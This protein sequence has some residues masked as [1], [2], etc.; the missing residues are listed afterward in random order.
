MT[1]FHTA[2]FDAHE[3]VCF[4]ADADSGLRAIIAVHWQGPGLAGGGIRMWPYA[5]EQ[6]A[7]TDALR[8]SRA[9]TYKFALADIAIGG[10]KTVVIGDSRT[11]KT[12]ALLRTLGRAVDSLGGRYICGPDVG[13]TP[14]DMVLIGETTTHVRGR[15]GESGDT[16]PATGYGVFQA[17]RAAVRQR[18]GRQDLDGLKVAVQGAGAV[19]AAL[20]RHLH[21]A[22]AQI[23]IADID[24]AAVARAEQA[25][26]AIAMAPQQILTAEADVLAP[27]ALGA[28]LNDES[29]P[30]IR[31]AVICGGANNQL[32]EDRHGDVLAERGIL[33]VPDYV[34][35][36]GGAINASA[37][38]PDYDADRAWQRVGR[39]YDTCGQIFARAE[40]DGIPASRAAD[41]MA[42][43]RIGRL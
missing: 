2:D 33:Y 14:E 39:I 31:A 7:I 20:C 38:G 6:K 42:A 28:V 16:S 37:E 23:I 25:Y 21:E 34:A 4:F 5:D 12:P 19:G 41:R 22:G 35:N 8:L 24:A 27:C 32:A 10:G 3:Q 9:M 40:A 29:I 18:L 13:T 17:L 1:V 15:P 43:E 11:E 30:A 36:A 26:G